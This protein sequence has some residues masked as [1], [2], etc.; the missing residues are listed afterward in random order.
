MSDSIRLES[1]TGSGNALT[2]EDPHRFSDGRAEVFVRVGADE[3]N[4]FGAH[5][6]PTALRDWLLEHFPLPE[7]A[8]RAAYNEADQR[9]NGRTLGNFS[10]LVGSATDKA[11]KAAGRAY[12]EAYARTFSDEIKAGS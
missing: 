1:T 10:A 2:I 11:T 4:G 6:D 5:I 3:Y 12:L 7:A 8:D 9:A